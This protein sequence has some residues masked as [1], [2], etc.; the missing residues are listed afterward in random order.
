MLPPSSIQAFAKLMPIDS[1]LV[2]LLEDDRDLAELL[3]RTLEAHGYTVECFDLYRRFESRL[4]QVHPMICVID[5]SLP[6]KRG[7]DT[8]MRH[9]AKAAVPTIL[10]SGVYTELPD[11]VLGLELGADDFLLKPFSPRELVARIN[12]IIRR[13]TRST[14]EAANAVRFAGWTFHVDRLLLIAPDGEEISMGGNE[15]RLLQYLI[16]NAQRVVSR[17]RLLD[18]VSTTDSTALDRSV[19]VR[20]SRLRA[21]LRDQSRNPK[22]IKTVYGQ[23]YIFVE[24]VE[25]LS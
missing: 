21:K 8:V 18:Q 11:R 5:A 20:I 9:L 1:N 13:T 24:K 19:D 25:R 22:I 7:V 17:D 16:A 6:D 15:A 2:F 3:R 14:V 4:E 10:I 23:G 12:S